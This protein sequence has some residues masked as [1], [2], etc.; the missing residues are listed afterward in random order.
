MFTLSRKKKRE[1]EKWVRRKLKF[2]KTKLLLV[3]W[4]VSFLSPCV[5]FLVIFM[6]MINTEF[7]EL[8]C[9]SWISPPFSLW[10]VWS[11]EV[12]PFMVA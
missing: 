9:W 12:S 2:I 7:Y 8:P 3:F 5:L 4:P 1:R 10:S 11:S 6:A